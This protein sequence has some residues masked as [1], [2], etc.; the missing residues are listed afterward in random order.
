MKME[1]KL[2]FKHQKVLQKS[3]EA[4]REAKIEV[5]SDVS[6]ISEAIR[7]DKCNS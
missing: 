4:L 2:K 1:A 6:V 5:F 3:V 7:A